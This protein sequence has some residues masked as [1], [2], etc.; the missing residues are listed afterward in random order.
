[1]VW[2][3]GGGRGEKEGVFA[4]IVVEGVCVCVLQLAKTGS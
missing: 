4:G 2:V 3:G 1:M